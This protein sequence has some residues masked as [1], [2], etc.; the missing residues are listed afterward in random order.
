MKQEE[1]V[2]F[3]V[4]PAPRTVCCEHWHKQTHRH[5]QAVGH[6]Q[7]H[8]HR[9]AALSDD[10]GDEKNGSAD[11]GGSDAIDEEKHADACEVLDFAEQQQHLQK[12]RNCPQQNRQREKNVLE[13]QEASS[14]IVQA[15]RK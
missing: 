5:E 9:D 8:A 2:H 6:S 3:A 7:S 14:S 11:D 13:N 1:T 10:C 12:R 4:L 15:R